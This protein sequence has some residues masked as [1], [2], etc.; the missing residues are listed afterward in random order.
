M[1]WVLEFLR[2][3]SRRWSRYAATGGLDTAMLIVLGAYTILALDR[4]GLQMVLYPRPAV[5]LVLAGLYGWLGLAG[6]VWLVGRRRFPEVTFRTVFLLV[7]FA[8]TP[9]VVLGLTIQFT[10]VVL[11]FLGPA[12]S[13]AIFTTVFWLPALLT[14]AVRAAYL[15]DSRQSLR[16]VIGP[17]LLWLAVVGR[18]LASQLGHLI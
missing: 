7:G 13:I 10:S 11:Q 5:R 6:M 1:T 17:Y 4:L 9:L 15:I 16:L 3:D 12:F 8:H 18:Y 2:L 14:A